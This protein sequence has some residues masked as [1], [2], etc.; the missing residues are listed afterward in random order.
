MNNTKI[1]NNYANG[2]WRFIE[3]YLPNYY[4]RDDILRD[5]ILLRFVEDEDVY[6]KDLVWIADEF[7]SNKKLIVEEIIRLE[8]KFAEE[9]LGA[10]YE[11]QQRLTT[12]IHAVYKVK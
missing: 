2:F 6:E 8:T 9:A 5:D 7:D 4:S 3:E 10:Y 12:D 11:Q 1:T